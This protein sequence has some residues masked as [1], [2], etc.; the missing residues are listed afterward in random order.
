MYETVIWATDGMEGA[1]WALVAALELA[2]ASNGR[3]VA[4]HVDQ[5]LTGRAGG[6]PVLPDESELFARIH[7]QVDALAARV[8]T[9]LVVRRTH[10]EPAAMIA[11]VA[12]ELDAD[13]I[14]C[15]THG[16]TAL[17]GAVLG[18]VAH[19]L[20]HVAPCPVLVVPEHA[21]SLKAPEEMPALAE[22]P[23]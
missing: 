11:A 19:A 6:W 1:D 7:E 2:T 3:I 10:H 13:V 5:R 17:G 15:G 14:V 21:K 18:S 20:L 22:V 12:E 9:Q 8:P 23:A 16:R 4:V